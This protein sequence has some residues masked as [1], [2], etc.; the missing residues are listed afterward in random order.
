[1]T[2]TAVSARRC[3]PRVRQVPLAELALARLIY[4]LRD[5]LERYR[6]CGG[7][8]RADLL[9]SVPADDAEALAKILPNGIRAISRLVRRL[10]SRVSAETLDKAD[11]SILH[12]RT[13]RHRRSAGYQEQ[14]LGDV[15]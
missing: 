15:T 7:L 10:E 11:R 4:Q 9:Q 6:E 1:M 5:A 13:V 8:D 14:G 2:A 12:S 3:S